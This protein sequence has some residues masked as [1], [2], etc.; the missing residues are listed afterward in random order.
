MSAS[1]TQ[2]PQLP[3]IAMIATPLPF[4]RTP[5]FNSTNILSY[6]AFQTPLTPV[7]PSAN[8]GRKRKNK[9]NLLPTYDPRKRPKVDLTDLEKIRMFYGFI[10]EELGW[11]YGETLYK[12]SVSLADHNKNH[13][14]AIH[15]L[16]K[17]SEM[18]YHATDNQI[19]SVNPSFWNFF[20]WGKEEKIC[21]VFCSEAQ[22]PTW[23]SSRAF[24][25]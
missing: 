23:S 5:A 14:A 6:S 18:R 16:E 2:D 22:P 13:K 1:T 25:G 8:R 24:V 19:M 10:K 4:S 15:P 17:R 9:E 3:V 7:S 20:S 12:T 21:I 11:T